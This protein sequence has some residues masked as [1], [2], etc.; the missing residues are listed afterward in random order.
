MVISSTLELIGNTPVVQAYSPNPE[1]RIFVKLEK[2][3]PG[4]SVKDRPA[5]FMIEEA[6]R[7]G[8]LRKGRVVV[9]PTS[10]NTGIGLALVCRIKG[11]RFIAVMPE[12]ASEERKRHLLYLG[13]EI[14]LSDAG[15]GIDGA[16]EEAARILAE[17]S[18][19]FVGPSSGA[20]YGVA[21][22][23]AKKL[24]KGTIVVMA[25][26]GRE[27]YLSMKNYSC[28]ICEKITGIKCRWMR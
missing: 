20:A 22:Q 4:G 24:D 6:E 8:L 10:G 25:P 2:F 5:K 17:K 7:H 15:S 12:D 28:E 18:G 21:Y 16:S 14:V 3:N 9:E 11:Y 13:A 1:V 19:V 26:D 23:I 27:R